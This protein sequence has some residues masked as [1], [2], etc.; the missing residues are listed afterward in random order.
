MTL[1]EKRVM[2]TY[3]LAKLIVWIREEKGWEVALDEGKVFSLRIGLDPTT[4]KK[5]SFVDRVHSPNSKHYEGLAAD[6][7]LYVDKVY[8]DRDCAEWQALG[9]KWLSLD[10][11]CTW[12]GTWAKL[13]LNHLSLGE[14]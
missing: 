6:L 14:R 11:M 10:P 1:R 4:D 5:T 9:A 13:D 8:K 2:F 12:G 3:L 7:N